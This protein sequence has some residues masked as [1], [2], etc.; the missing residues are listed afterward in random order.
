MVL[1]TESTEGCNPKQLLD[2]SLSCYNMNA[3]VKHHSKQ[4]KK[5]HD[6]LHEGPCT[7]GVITVER[8]TKLL[9]ARGVT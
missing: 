1:I 8:C 9:L 4:D 7:R 6:S 2:D 5:A 3:L